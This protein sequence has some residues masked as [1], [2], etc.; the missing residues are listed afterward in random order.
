MRLAGAFFLAALLVVTAVASAANDDLGGP[1]SGTRAPDISAST[2]DGR[3]LS[4]GAFRGKTVVLNFWASWCP[5]C[6]AEAND[7]AASAV[8]EQSQGVVF[9]GVD[10][11][12]TLA[13]IR[14]F[15]AEKNVPFK[16]VV[17]GSHRIASAYDVHEIPTTFVIDPR[18]VIRARLVSGITRAKLRTYIAAAQKG[19]GAVDLSPAQR[20]VDASLDG[21]RYSFE[22]SDDDA[23]ANVG[24]AL[25][26][27]DGAEKMLGDDSPVS[28]ELDVMRTRAEEQALRGRA[29]AAF[30]NLAGTPE[31]R[32]RLDEL[33]GDYAYFAGRYPEAISAF[34]QA[35]EI[36]PSDK[37][38]LNAYATAAE[39]MHAYAGAVYA[40]SRLVKLSP[41]DP[42]A[43]VDLATAYAHIR[44]FPQAIHEVR[45]AIALG[46]GEVARTPHDTSARRRLAWVHLYAGRTYALAGDRE[47][48]RAEFAATIHN[49]TLLPPG[50]RRHDMYVEEAQEATVA[51][52]LDRGAGT[53]L[54]LVPWTGAGLPGSIPGTIRYRLVAAGPSNKQ[55]TLHAG[56]IPKQWVASFCSKSV[57][58][59]GTVSV[60]LPSSGIAVVEFQLVP[61]SQHAAVDFPV[62][63]TARDAARTIRAQASS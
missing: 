60:R 18:G 47:S 37:A 39:A 56:P 17:D 19:D 38:A 4:L 5:P 9:I 58:S 20:A 30:E 41:A 31:D 46:G 43:R 51:L 13:V 3:P 57:C 16:Q 21:A 42:G 22:G 2:L 32:A 40:D 8:E 7:I 28:D 52:A 14:A 36:N 44:A 23:R 6:R 54:S 62:S 26:A 55:I 25:A 12:E 24:R 29:I 1:Q 35:T 59:P 45:S 27:I 63:V 48:A 11:T 34:G 53:T 15:V 10:S 50:D 49:A 61:P 33:E